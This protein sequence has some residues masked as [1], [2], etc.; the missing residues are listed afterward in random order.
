MD[1]KVYGIDLGTTYSAIAWINDFGKAEILTNSDGELTTP[2]VVYFE[3]EDNIVAGREA[4][5][6]GKVDPDNVVS[7]IKREMGRETDEKGNPLKIRQFFGKEYTPVHI[8]S[9]IL[10]RLIGDVRAT[11]K[12]VNKVV[13]TCPAYFNPNEREATRAAGEMAGVEVLRILDEP[14][15]AALQYCDLEQEEARNVIVYDLGGGTFDVTIVRFSPKEGIEVVCTDGDHR[16]G[17]ADW[18]NKLVDYV[19]DEFKASTETDTDIRDD[20][21]SMYDVRLQCENAK[22]LL[23]KTTTTN[24]S[25]SHEGERVKVTI[26]REIFNQLT[27]P[28]LKKTAETTK[29]MIELARSKGITEF[30]EFLLVGGSSLMPQV[31]EMV[32]KEFGEPLGVEP[33]I[34][35][36]NEVVAK[37][38]AI[39]AR[40]R[41]MLKILEQ[42]QKGVSLPPAPT[43]DGITLGGIGGITTVASKSCGIRV[44]NKDRKEIIYNM[45][46]KQTKLPCETSQKIPVSQDNA[47][48]V[49]LDIFFCNECSKFVEVHEA[50]ELGQARMDLDEPLNSGD[51]IEVTL[52]LNDEGAV[53]LHARDLKSGKEVK[54][55]FDGKGSVSKEEI[56]QVKN[57]APDVR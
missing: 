50:E 43:P 48:S 20:S 54:A 7:L 44:L 31:M 55:S 56:D 8:S 41:M 30:H 17:G 5:E 14:V 4:K 47:T 1:E 12:E 18:D 40:N 15:A 46:L 3:S 19:I 26:T 21:E 49:P 27:E 9:L 52:G 28:L 33:R 51:L 53:S 23:S 22:K 13:I 25:I 11:G 57:S 29:E 36:P 42:K 39:Y 38:A 37:G 45:I 10:R 2:S 35:E 34:F 24:Q 16:L 32:K 6:S